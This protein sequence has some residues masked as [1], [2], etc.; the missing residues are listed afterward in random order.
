MDN[1]L[2]HAPDSFRQ[3]RPHALSEAIRGFSANINPSE[4]EGLSDEEQIEWARAELVKI[5]DD[6][7]AHLEGVKAALDPWIIE[8][9]RLEAADR[10]LFDL[11]AGDGPGPQVR[12]RH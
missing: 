10:C 3:T 9:S 11:P 12:G 6:E 5:I 7:V 8:Q 1:L 4:I 2:G